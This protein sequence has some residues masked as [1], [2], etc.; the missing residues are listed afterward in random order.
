MTTVATMIAMTKGTS[1][2]QLVTHNEL[3]ANS[4]LTRQ[5]DIIPINRLDKPVTVIGCGAIGSYVLPALAKMGMMD[6]T[7]W[8][9]DEVSIENMSNQFFR[10]SD[11]GQNK[12]TAMYDIIEDFTGTKMKV[13]PIQ[14]TA[15]HAAG[16]KGIVVLAV[17]SMAARRMIFDAIKE[18]GFNVEYMIDPRMS[19][20]FYAQYTI[21]PFSDTDRATYESTMYTDDNAVAER[22]TAKS[23]V[24]TAQLAGGLI[25]KTIKNIILGED[26]PRN[27]QWDIKSSMNPMVMFSG[28]A[29]GLSSSPTTDTRQAQE[30]SPIWA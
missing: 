29:R 17:D 8:D 16:L 10:R 9:M 5:L 28:N 23:T 14:F 30:Q 11:I 21:N 18:Q 12:A 26:F 6:I 22:C 1:S 20:E 13:M 15:A 3:G 4:H 7:G 2:M 19:A 27:T 25:V 24:Y